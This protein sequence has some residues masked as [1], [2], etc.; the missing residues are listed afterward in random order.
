MCGTPLAEAAERQAARKTV[1]VL[2]CDVAGFTQA[3]ERLDPE[4]LRELQSRYFDE[5]RAALERHGG[6]VEKFIG[7]AVMAVFGVPQLHEDDALRAVRAAA[8]LGEA[9][10]ALGLGIRIGVNTGEVVAGSGDALVTGD[11]VN[12][13]ARLEQTA[14]TGDILVGEATY[15]LV[16]D[17]VRVEP[18]PALELAGKSA[19]IVAF[20][21]IEVTPGA[22]G[23]TRRLDAPLVGR[24]NELELLRDAFARATRERACHLVTVL[25]AP[26]VG[27]SRLVSEFLSGLGDDVTVARGRCLSYGEG[28]TFWPL[29]EAVR[30]ALAPSGGE[31]GRALEDAVADEASGERVAALV[32]ESIGLSTGSATTEETFWAFRKLFESLSRRSPLVLVLDDIQWGAPTFLDLVEHLADWT[33]DAP[34]LL[35]CMARPDL[36]DLSS[37]WGGGKLNATTFLLEPL[38][39]DETNALIGNLL[40]GELPPEAAGRISAA[41]EGNALFVEEMVGMLVDDGLLVRRN[42]GWSV[43]GD[44]DRVEVPPT[45]RALLAARIDRLPEADRIVL[46]RAAVEGQIFHASA[47]AELAPAATAGAVATS[48]MALVR[49]ELVRPER[50]TFA[51]EEAFRF[52]HLLIRDAAYDALPKTTRADL[53]ERFADWLERKAGDRAD[54]F[55]ELL[56]YHLEEA[57]RYVV[58]VSPRD[59]RADALAARAGS[60]LAQAGRRALARR[61]LTA[62]ASLLGRSAAL[63]PSADR[64]RLTLL[65]DLAAALGEIGRVDEARRWLAEAIERSASVDE[66]THARA[67]AQDAW[68]RMNFDNAAAEDVEPEVRSAIETLERLGDEYGLGPALRTLGDVYN[69][70]GEGQRWIGTLANAFE[71]AS[72]SENRYEEIISLSIY[73]GSMFFGPTPAHE[74]VERLSAIRRRLEDDP[75]LEAALLRP[76]GGFVAMTGEID[77]GRLLVARSREVFREFGTRWLLAGIPFMSGGIEL[78]AGDLQA[79]E[80][81]YRA[82]VEE[83]Q[84]IGERGRA[85]T[86]AAALARVLVLQG[87]EREAAEAADLG[88]TLG[89]EDDLLTQTIASAVRAKVLAESGELE[90]AVDLAEAAWSRLMRTDFLLWTA[91][92]AEDVA[93]VYDAAGRPA[94]AR[95]FRQIALDLNERKG[96]VVM[97]ERLGALLAAD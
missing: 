41:A 42:G 75:L 4:A 58:E 31:L 87:R 33:R 3:G 7:D 78:L 14:A 23:R 45:I 90:C 28:I 68:W 64:D 39:E 16:E 55:A 82:G 54:E 86:L 59:P 71:Y 15:R 9:V 11:A 67:C 60:R 29:A 35:L 69:I 92:A 21:L 26:G 72:R 27:K 32:A 48:L 85:S 6:T 5:A 63:L 74:G 52:R 1:T 93:D 83:Y 95:R 66:Q 88:S 62:A 20:R 81:E 17:A 24:H 84:R 22:E 56:G 25:G 37:G 38:A 89:G 61:D 53:H 18:L 44:L 79:A 47:V 49:R 91:Y 80:R 8:E 40:G 19:P 34:V 50:G 13:A 70:R 43:A 30:E 96:N 12:V 97:V 2:F 10:A 65:P 36:L 51:D 57:N 73:G 77:E 46:G 76:L 94:E